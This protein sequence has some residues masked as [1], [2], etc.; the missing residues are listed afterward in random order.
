ME[1]LVAAVQAHGGIT[2]RRLAQR[3]DMKKSKVN[4]LLHSQRHFQKVERSPLSHVNARVVWFWSEIPVALPKIRTRINSKNKS[5]KRIAL[6]ELEQ[7]MSSV[8][9][10]QSS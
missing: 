3:L 8:R 7:K 5:L 9:T 10:A 4:A 1:S 6:R 2:A